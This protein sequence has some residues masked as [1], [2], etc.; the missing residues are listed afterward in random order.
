MYCYN[1]STLSVEQFPTPEVV[2]AFYHEVPSR[3]RN[4]P[5]PLVLDWLRQDV[6]Y[7][8]ESGVAAG[9]IEQIKSDHG[10]ETF[11]LVLIDGSEFTG[12][13]E[14]QLVK[15]AKLIL[16]DDTNTFKC[17]KVRQA[18]LND[19]MYDLLA[20][21]QEL[22]N[23]YSAFRR[24]TT[25]RK[26]GNT[27]P[28]HFF[29]IVLNGEP[30]IRYHE[31]VFQRLTVPW[32]WHIVEGV[33]ALR[34]DTAWS[35]ALGGQ[36]PDSLHDRGLSNDGTAEYLDDLAKRFPE[37]I[38]IYRKRRGELWDGKKEMVNAPLRNISEACLL[39]QVDSDEL[40]TVE[41]IQAVHDLFMRHPAKTAAYYWCWYFVGP[42][43][44]ISTR[45]N[46]AQDPRQ[47]WLRTWRYAPGA[48]WAAH[49][50]P[51][52]VAAEGKADIAK[53]DA[54]THDVMEQAGV[55]FQHFAYATEPQLTFKEAYYGY[56]DALSRWRRLQAH[57]GSGALKDFFHW[58]SDGTMFDDAAH[59]FVDPLAQLDPSSGHWRFDGTGMMPSERCMTAVQRPRIVVD[60]VFW[61][62]LTS[63]IGRVWENLLREWVASGFAE[64]IIVLDRAGSAPRI[65]GIHYWTIRRHDYLQTGRD[66]LYLEAICRRLD[67][68]IFASTYYSTPTATP[69][70]FVGYDMIPEVLGF[71]Q[72][73]E[74]WQEKRRAILHASGRSMI[75]AN[76]ARD[77]EKLYPSMNGGST[78]VTRCGAD[79]VFTRPS[80]SVVTAFR[81]KHRLSDRTYVIMVGERVG[82]C[83][84]K[85][86]A[87]AFRALARL[88]KD[89]SIGT[90]LRRG[91]AGD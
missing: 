85:N 23:G 56:K 64:N 89:K 30:F 33:A 73:E 47:E 74:T 4:Y 76:S 17:L 44:I 25:P 13:L 42:A 90:G 84:Y 83:G 71:P 36:I 5:L 59:Y 41:Q 87:L 79:K 9:A 45:Y 1:R 67:A 54:F 11:D 15:G 14:Y 51:I 80:P 46:Y 8:R 53:L 29:T 6:Q 38:T 40:W 86:G 49:E 88:P 12:S 81:A 69:S 3:L 65:Q 28:I 48:V 7:V 27:L 31:R 52:L 77:L 78:Y 20:D 50:P 24:R 82:F 66:S 19:P 10:V 21:N 63:G 75:S 39:W 35:V 26:V 43:K 55:V 60:G 22:R 37:N 58:V 57:A 62:Y 72:H 18:L 34:H 70:F 61:Q 32:H 2:T 91:S 68:D 16:L